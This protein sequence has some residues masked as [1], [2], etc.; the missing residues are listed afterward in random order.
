MLGINCFIIF[1]GLVLL[2]SSD[3]LIITDCGTEDDIFE[4]KSISVKPQEIPIPGDVTVSVDVEIYRDLV[5]AQLDL[6]V[7]IQTY[8]GFFWTSVPC[9]GDVGSCTY[10]GCKLLDNFNATGCP[11]QLANHNIPCTCDTIKAGKYSLPS[12]KISIPAMSGLW[13]WLATGDYKADL[14][15]LDR[16]TNKH[17]GCLHVE[18]TIVD[19]TACSG[20]LCSIF[21]GK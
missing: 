8:L 17:V 18:V 16:T 10:D 5:G 14:K 21:G 3:P 20:F 19:P 6:E 2:V 7:Y 13:S 15:L 4:I 12:E 1:F 11:P 9:I